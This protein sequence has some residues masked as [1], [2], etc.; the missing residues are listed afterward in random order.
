MQH[1]LQQSLQHTHQVRAVRDSATPIGHTATLAATHTA[2][3]TATHS[4]TLTA[5]L[6]PGAGGA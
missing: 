2:T 1:E 4:A 3:L 5:S 6:T